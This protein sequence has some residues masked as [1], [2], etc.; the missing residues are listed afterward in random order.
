M[1]RSRIAPAAVS[2]AMLAAACSDASIAGP[3][4]RIASRA[5]IGEP[6]SGSYIVVKRQRGAQAG[7]LMSRLADAGATVQREIPALSVVVV[8]GLSAEAAAELAS[9]ASVAAITPDVMLQWLPPGEATLG[10][11]PRLKGSSPR[12]Q[13]TDQSGA[14]FFPIQWNLRRIQA[15]AAWGVTPTGRGATVCVLDT[16]VDPEHQDLLG[17]VDLTISKSFVPDEPFIADLNAHGT[18]V[19]SLIAANGIAMASVAPDARLCAVKVLGANGSGAFSW[20]IAGMIHAAD[21][22]ADVLN[23][24]LGAYVDRREPG[25]DVLIRALADAIAYARGKGAQVVVA[26]GNDG[27]NLAEDGSMISIPA[28]I[29]GALA[30]TATAPINQMNFDRLAS[31]ANFGRGATDLAAPGGDLVDGGI[32]IDL[33]LG[34]CSR[35]VCGEDG[36]YLLGGGTSFAAPM[37]SAASAVVESNQTRDLDAYD[38]DNCILQGVDRIFRG[39]SVR[40]GRYGAGRLNVLQSATGCAQR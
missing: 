20:I 2:L 22:G 5:S 18:F 1:I 39:L 23:M 9:D 25:V 27:A 3:T 29:T 16:G 28:E 26:T 19:S 11:Q 10:S 24:S 14:F 30:V 35:F 36:F 15:D 13:G 21:V 38:L 40:D 31:Y 17:K 6:I 8:Q 12:V 7:A 37:V 4:T 34:V 33:V 32:D